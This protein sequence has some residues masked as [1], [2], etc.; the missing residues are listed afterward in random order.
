MDG[1]LKALLTA[2]TV[3]LVM[4]VARHCGPRR[5]GLVAA[6]PTVTAPTLVWLV[7]E[8]G[9]TFAVNAAIGSVAACAMLAAFSVVYA[10]LARRRG[11]GVALGGGLLGALALAGPALL[12]SESLPASMTLALAACGVALAAMPRLRPKAPDGQRSGGH[13]VYS[14]LASGGLSVL[15]ASAG[16]ALGSFATGLLASLPVAS[17]V[18]AVIEHAAGGH[19]AVV[20]FLSGYVVGLFGK[21]AFGVVFVLLAAALGSAWALALGCAVACGVSALIA[22]VLSRAHTDRVAGRRAGEAAYP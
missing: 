3:A 11:V 7:H 9:L 10:T 21:I 8:R 17:G 18:V 5:A 2:A 22:R 12:V 16:P 1:W 14:S 13:T 15:A 4:V 20:R 6:L 19:H